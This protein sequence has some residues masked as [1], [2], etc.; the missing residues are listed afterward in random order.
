MDLTQIKTIAA[1]F[2]IVDENGKKL[3]G[4]IK[5]PYAEKDGFIRHISQVEKGLACGCS[6]PVC[7]Q[8][9]I[10]RKGA[11]KRHHF[12]HYPDAVCNAETVLHYLAKRLLFEKLQTLL[13]RKVALVLRWKCQLCGD[14]HSFNFFE[15]VQAIVSEKTL[16]DCRPDLCLVDQHGAPTALIEIVVAHPPDEKVLIFVSRKQIPLLIFR[17]R[18]GEE[19]EEMATCPTINPDLIIHCPRRR[20]PECGAPLFEK[21]LYILPAVCW[22]CGAG[23]NLAFLDID[24]QVAGTEEFSA[25]DR[26]IISRN[27]VILRDTIRPGDRK[28]TVSHICP[29]CGVVTGNAYL[30]YLKRHEQRLLVQNSGK[31]C[32]QCHR[33][34]D[35]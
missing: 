7:H 16:S 24:G 30:R 8:P 28:R 26:Q 33:H 14:Q 25:K 18:S 10:A 4:T 3:P 21:S 17:I 12:A 22:R 5:I 23:M 11:H 27:N 34:F 29:H 6:C 20:C 35:E 15:N 1:G 32:R 19:M 31:Y 13:K 2:Y 9:V